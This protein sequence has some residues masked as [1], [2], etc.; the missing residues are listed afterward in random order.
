M[1]PRFKF[2]KEEIVQAALDITRENGMTALTAR[3]LA[4]KLG[5][6]VKPVFGAFKNM[7]EVQKEVMAA[8]NRMYEDYLKTDMAKGQYP[9]YKASGMAYIR[10]A[11]E[12][13]H[14]FKLLFMR[15]RSGEKIEE[16]REELRPLIDLIKAS[17]G[18]S[19]DDAYLFHLEMWIYVHGIATMAATS[20]L[21]WDDEFV[22]SVLTDAYTGLKYRF[23][24]PEGMPS[25]AASGSMAGPV[26]D[27]ADG[28][29]AT[30]TGI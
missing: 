10:F 28:S 19:E 8:A 30:G 1:P 29:T 23:S 27:T 2:T 13:P 20:Y 15:D 17:L 7:E 26:T 25:A 9:P 14:L 3:A 22:S 21:D 16:N 11:K 12:E 4:A 18:I 6:S 24:E 5:C